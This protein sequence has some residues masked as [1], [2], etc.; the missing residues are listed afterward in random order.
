MKDEAESY[1]AAK[2]F[3]SL[4]KPGVVVTDILTHNTKQYGR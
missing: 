2:V 3:E 1:E 4:R